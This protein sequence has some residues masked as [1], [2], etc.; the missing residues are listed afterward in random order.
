MSI[1][2]LA[3]FVLLGLNYGWSMACWIVLGFFG[4]LILLAAAGE[5]TR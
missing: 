3:I 5:S 1:V 4:L 2:S